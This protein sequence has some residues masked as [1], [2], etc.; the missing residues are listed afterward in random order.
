MNTEKQILN[1]LSQVDEKY[2]EEAA[3]GKSAK[4]KSVW[5]KWG[6]V[7]ACFALVVA[8]GFGA[9]QGG[10]FLGKDIATLD[11]GEAIG[12]VKSNGVGTFALDLKFSVT[13]RALTDDE[14]HALFADLPVTA[15]AVFSE[16]DH[17]L[18]GLEGA[19]QGVKLVIATS[20]TPMMDTVIAGIEEST[21]VNSVPVRAGYFVTDPNS[22]GVQTAIYF[23]TF[24]LG[25]ST[26]YVE[27]AGTKA[28]RE[29][30]KNELA[31]VVQALIANG[32]LDTTQF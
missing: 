15:S 22:R 24:T 10:W 6:A 14:T 20:G 1:V 26:F 5:M 28:A 8:L 13:A 12:F 18:I 3:P 17:Q 9:L 25:N 29:T 7:A 11:S 16:A 21:L 32:V 4:K 23:A 19:M 2:I 30:V 27:N 31:A